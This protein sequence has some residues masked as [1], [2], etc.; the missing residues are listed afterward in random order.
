[1]TALKENYQ[2]PFEGLQ[3]HGSADLNLFSYKECELLENQCMENEL[4]VEKI[5]QASRLLKKSETA[6]EDFKRSFPW[7]EEQRIEHRELI[8]ELI[9]CG[10][11]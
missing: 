8:E 2:P 4:T 5:R 6:Q 7:T 1:M 10:N 11:L 3:N 9:K